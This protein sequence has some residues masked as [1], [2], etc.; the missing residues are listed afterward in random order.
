MAERKTALEH[1]GRVEREGD[2]QQEIIHMVI[3]AKT[4]SP[5]KNRVN[6]AHA[7]N[8]NGE[9]EEMTVSEPSH[10]KRLIQKSRRASGKWYHSAIATVPSS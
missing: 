6:R 8:Q 5:Q 4:F 1:G 10:E 2:E 7:V 3:L 9:Q